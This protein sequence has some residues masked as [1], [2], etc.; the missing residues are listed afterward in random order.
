MSRHWLFGRPGV[1]QAELQSDGCQQDSGDH[2]GQAAA[3]ARGRGAGHQ[4]RRREGGDLPPDRREDAGVGGSARRRCGAESCAGRATPAGPLGWCGCARAGQPRRGMCS[5]RSASS[6][7]RRSRPRPTTSP[8]P[9]STRPLPGLPWQP[10][11]SVAAG[12][13]RLSKM[14]WPR[15]L[16]VADL[17]TLGAPGRRCGRSALRRAGPRAVPCRRRAAGRGGRP[18]R[19]VDIW[20]AQVNPTGT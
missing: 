4:L 15:A 12:R 2:R 14:S 8:A 10:D 18:C 3:S 11:T 6:G 17:P 20:Q 5:A 19:G 9:R 1:A 13:C 16:S 7:S